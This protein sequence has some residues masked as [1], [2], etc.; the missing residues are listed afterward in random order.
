MLPTIVRQH[1]V[2]PDL[3]GRPMLGLGFGLDRLAVGM[4]PCG[5]QPQAEDDR[6]HGPDKGEVPAAGR[7][8]AGHQRDAEAGEE[9][10]GDKGNRVERVPLHGDLLGRW[11]VGFAGASLWGRDQPAVEVTAGATGTGAAPRMTRIWPTEA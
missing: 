3:A 5:K 6:P 11:W 10:A 7:D 1:L 9:Q 2:L 4:A 8:P